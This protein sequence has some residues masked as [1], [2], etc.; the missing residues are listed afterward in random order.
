VN[1]IYQNNYMTTENLQLASRL[2]QEHFELTTPKEITIF[3]NII[4]L[5]DLQAKLSEI[6]FG[7]LNGNFEKLLQILYRVDVSQKKFEEAMQLPNLTESA[8]QIANL[9]IERELEKVTWR[10]KYKAV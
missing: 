3:E 6:I 2:L 9:I 4:D 10:M 7:L 5:T 1:K 8:L